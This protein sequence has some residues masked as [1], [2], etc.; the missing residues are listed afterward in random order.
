MVKSAHWM[1]ERWL[2]THSA[3]EED[4]GLIPCTHMATLNLL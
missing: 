1:L 3:L 2:S 4:T